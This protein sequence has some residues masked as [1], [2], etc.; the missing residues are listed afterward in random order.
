MRQRLSTADLSVEELLSG[1]FSFSVP[2]YQRQYAW[3]RDEAVQLIDDIVGVLED[4]G[5]ESADTPYFLGAMLFVTNGNGEGPQ[6][7][8]VVDGQQQLI[9]LV[10]LLAVLRDLASTEDEKG[11]ID[12]LLLVPDAGGGRRYQ[13]GL[14]QSDDAFLRIAIQTQGATRRSQPPAT[15][16]ENVGRANVEEVR[17]VL[18]HKLMKEFDKAGRAAFLAF[19]R[20]HVRVLVVTSDDLDYAYQIFLTINDRGKRLS[21]EDIFR[22]EILGPLDGDQR[23]RFENV[24][25]EMDR[26]METG[27]KKRAKGKTFF[28]HL[29]TIYGWSGQGIIA[30]LRR[31]VAEQG[32][33][34]RF[35]TEVFAP[36]AEAYLVVKRSPAAR[37]LSLDL[38]HWLTALGWLEQHGDDDWVPAAMLGLVRLAGDDARLRAYLAALDRYA[39]ALMMLGCGREARRRHYRPIVAQVLETPEVP[40]P[41][42]LFVLKSDDQRQVLHAVATRLHRLDPATARL[43]LLRADAVVTGRPLAT[44][45][46]L[47]A[48]GQP[49][50]RRI[51]VEHVC[52]KGALEK[53]DWLRLFPRQT[54][55][56][57]AAECIGNLVLVSEAQNKAAAQEDFPVKHRIFFPDDKGLS[58]ELTEMLRGIEEWNA[59]AI[60]VRY[61]LIMQT[62]KTLWALEGPIPRC[63]AARRSS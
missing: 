1:R 7:V 6:P 57:A 41:A 8:D 60:Q 36:M 28:S 20:Q 43:V 50:S 53:G 34:R 45:S 18:R 37:A 30:G 40:D 51:S 26:Y 25:D 62:V 31:A 32:T 13:L 35:V 24:I 44:Y 46:P 5:R 33:P 19:L 17:R 23:R 63:P 29:A 47:L 59:E 2:P 38:E 14:R 16:G 56:M 3:S 15:I 22:G 54:R 11:S 21:V 9:T 49:A 27:E 61:D 55:R 42:T 4:T 48:P 12:R 10:I 58:L 39:H 52:P